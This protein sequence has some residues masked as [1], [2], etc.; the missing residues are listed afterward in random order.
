MHAEIIPDFTGTDI[1]YIARVNGVEVGRFYTYAAADAAITPDYSALLD[2]SAGDPEELGGP[3]EEGGEGGPN[4]DADP[5]AQRGA[6]MTE[7]P[8]F[9][10]PTGGAWP[11]MVLRRSDGSQV[12]VTAA[13]VEAMVRALEAVR[14]ATYLLGVDTKALRECIE[15]AEPLVCAALAPFEVQR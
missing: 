4:P 8:T 7:S 13:Q 12:T 6:A 10:I 3:S 14:R 9:F 11:E 1:R 15:D 5:A 2:V